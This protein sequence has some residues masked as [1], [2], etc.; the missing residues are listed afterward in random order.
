MIR[1]KQILVNQNTHGLSRKIKE[2][3]GWHDEQE[4]SD[5]GI[6]IFDL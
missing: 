1:K 3:V 5:L 4:C 6:V 2:S